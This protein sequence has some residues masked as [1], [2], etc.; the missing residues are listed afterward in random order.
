M[1]M[2]LRSAA[3]LGLAL[4]LGLPAAGQAERCSRDV[5]ALDGVAVS[6]RFCIPAGP[7]GANVNIGETFTSQGRNFSKTTPMTIVAGAQTS[8][9]I[10]DVDL[11]PIG[12]KHTLHMTLAFHDGRV[13]LEHALALPGAIPI[14]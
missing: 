11:A 6:A 8:R 7:A 5:F 12:S 13:V 4:G 2:L 1:G 3:A 10:D 14:K 9:T